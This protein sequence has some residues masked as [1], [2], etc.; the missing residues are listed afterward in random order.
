MPRLL[1]M[2]DM[3]LDQL[4][5][6]MDSF[7]P[8][9]E[10]V[11]TLTPNICS[12][13]GHDDMSGGVC[14]KCGLTV[15]FIDDSAEWRGGVSETGVSCDPSRVGMASD[16]LY[17]ANW[18]AGTIMKVA[19]KDRR[20]WGFVSKVN[21]HS[22]MNH[23]DRALHK[24]YGE[25]EDIGR[26]LGLTHTIT[27]TAKNT[28]KQLSE[29]VLTRG[30]I[31]TGM[32]ANCILRACK[33][34][35]V[36]RTTEEVAAAYEITTTDV[37]R[38][39][40]KMELLDKTSGFTD[41]ADIVPRI[42]S[43]LEIGRTGREKSVLKMRCIDMCRSIED[44]HELQG[45]TPK[46]VAVVVIYRV[47]VNHNINLDKAHFVNSGEISSATFNKIDSIIKKMA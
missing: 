28:Y 31:R 1:I 35:G 47:L 6:Q 3:S 13:C 5:S 20:K 25:F 22:S 10:V 18:G 26:K 16:P 24:S 46:A 7:L 41:P 27:V 40:H 33:Q 42:F 9:K 15:S 14:Y 38:T 21:T 29:K 39:A 11:P 44:C 30:A 37:S 2:A 34:H 8:A 32:K 19:Y 23:R 43:T 12:N 4:W 17:S 36:P 45:R